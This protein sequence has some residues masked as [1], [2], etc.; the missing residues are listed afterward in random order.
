MIS[1]PFGDV[2]T[3]AYLQNSLNL[4]TSPEVKHSEHLSFGA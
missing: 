2:E 4:K 1:S 3:E